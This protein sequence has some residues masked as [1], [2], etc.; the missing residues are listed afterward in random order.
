MLKN[1]EI[2]GTPKMVHFWAFLSSDKNPARQ[3]VFTFTHKTTY[4]KMKKKI[5]TQ[6][7]F[8][9]QKT[10]YPRRDILA[11]I[12]ALAAVSFFILNAIYF[13][14]EKDF[15][16]TMLE[17]AS[18]DIIPVF[19][20]LSVILPI[21]WIVF[22]F[23]MSLIVYKIEKKQ[24]RWYS[25]LVFSIISLFTFRIDCFILGLIASILYIKNHK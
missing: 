25:L 4:I 11:L 23:L 16:L 18:P 1:Q 14:T 6:N 13:L 24:Y 12:L 7:P 3:N 15:I 5:K 10:K 21:I 9:G 8:K 19:Q 22:A 2:F 17:A 20:S